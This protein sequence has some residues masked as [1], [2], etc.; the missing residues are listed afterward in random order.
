MPTLNLTIKRVTIRNNGRPADAPKTMTVGLIAQLTNPQ[1]DAHP[2]IGDIAKVLFRANVGDTVDAFGGANPGWQ[3]WGKGIA[4]PETVRLDLLYVVSYDDSFSHALIEG[5]NGF[6]SVWL[7]QV[8]FLGKY[9]KERLTINVDDVLTEEYGR[10]GMLIRP[11]AWTDS[12][13][14]PLT[15]K[16]YSRNDIRG[17]YMKP[18]TG[19]S[20]PQVSPPTTFVKAGELVAV[21]EMEA[22]TAKPKDVRARK[23]RGK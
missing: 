19:E 22:S 9:L 10:A 6:V 5:V 11:A 23:A 4:V 14:V 21:V 16:L 3:P 15:M 2:A 7:N 17:V 1:D 18:A 12:G 8:P 20:V 13:T